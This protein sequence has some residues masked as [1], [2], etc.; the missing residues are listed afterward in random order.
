MKLW[1]SGAAAAFFVFFPRSAGAR[2]VAARLFRPKRHWAVRRRAWITPIRRDDPDNIRQLIHSFG[3]Q[4]F[5][6]VGVVAK[7]HDFL[8]E[9]ADTPVWKKALPG[10][11]VKAQ[12]QEETFS[13]ALAKERLAEM[14]NDREVGRIGVAARRN[15]VPVLLD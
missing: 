5:R 8:R 3:S 6:H 13:P 10:L 15:R 14:I 4:A 9:V 1:S 11:S 7:R 12:P 2:L